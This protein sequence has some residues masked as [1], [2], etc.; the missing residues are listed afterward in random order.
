M[1]KIFNE[2]KHFFNKNLWII[3][4]T[5]FILSF[6]GSFQVYHGRFNNIIKEIS[7]IIVSVLKLFLFSPTEGFLKPQPLA[8][9]LAIWV[10]P[11]GTVL[12]TFSVFKKLYTVISLKIRHFNKEHIIVMGLNEYSMMFM[13]NFM[14]SPT[15]FK[16]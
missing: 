8:Y 2:I 6:I 1:K 15:R 7:V 3:Y 12:A 4:L 10:A 13:K 16:R 9:E 14:N 11:A 5:G